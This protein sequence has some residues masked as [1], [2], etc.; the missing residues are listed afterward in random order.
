MTSMNQGQFQQI[1]IVGRTQLATKC[2]E[3]VARSYPLLRTYYFNIG[4]ERPPKAAE[5]LKNLKYL[6]VEKN[7]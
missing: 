3:I 6:C 7:N 5:E 4:G 1:V 2:A